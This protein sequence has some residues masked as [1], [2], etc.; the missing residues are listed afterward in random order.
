MATS[1]FV[2]GCSGDSY[3][4]AE[5]P[6]ITVTPVV[7][8]PLVRIAW[9]P[10]GASQVRVYKGTVAFDDG[11]GGLLMWSVTSSAKNSLV[12]GIEY[13]DNPPAGGATDVVAKPL[14]GG[15]SYTVQVSR[16]DPKDPKDG[17]NGVEY[18]YTNT[19]TFQLPV[20]VPS[21]RIR[22]TP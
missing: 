12:S 2:L 4:A 6:R 20:T 13:G 21:S 11:S 22:P 15:Q 8:A 19:I 5:I 1:A 9:T 16:R 18:R 3:D 17:L 7:A 10:A 14:V